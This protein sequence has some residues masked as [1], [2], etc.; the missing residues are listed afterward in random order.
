[1]R[2]GEEVK[3]D[4]SAEKGKSELHPEKNNKRRS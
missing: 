1:M 2:G 4:K 3:M